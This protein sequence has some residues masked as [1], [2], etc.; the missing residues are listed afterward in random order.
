MSLSPD[1]VCGARGTEM[2]FR[3][4]SVFSCLSLLLQVGKVQK[5]TLIYMTIAG[6]HMIQ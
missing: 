5:H 1:V 2:H 4:M 3:K 6:N